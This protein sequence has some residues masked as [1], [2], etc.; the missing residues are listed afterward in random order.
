[1]FCRVF[2]LCLCVRGILSVK[3][4]HPFLNGKMKII[5]IYFKEIS[6]FVR[7]LISVVFQCKALYLK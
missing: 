1:M 6:S 5:K 3:I 4:V 2:I 7:I